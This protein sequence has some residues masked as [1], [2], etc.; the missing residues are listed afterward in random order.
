MSRILAKRTGRWTLFAALFGAAAMVATFW[1]IAGVSSGTA[2]TP[3]VADAPGVLGTP[4]IGPD[5]AIQQPQPV[6]DMIVAL[7]TAVT[8]CLLANGAQR[9]AMDETFAYPDPSGKAYAACS[10][11]L[12]ASHEWATGSTYTTYARLESSLIG[13]YRACMATRGVDKL[14]PQALDMARTDGSGA[15]CASVA[16]AALR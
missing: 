14:T 6:R 16:N 7:D 8:G 10:N 5:G 15:E 4:A 2:A 1:L 3:S 11:V 12:S 13:S 9:T